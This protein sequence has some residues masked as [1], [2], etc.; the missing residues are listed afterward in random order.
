MSPHTGYANVET[1]QM[2]LIQRINAQC[3]SAKDDLL[4]GLDNNNMMTF[5]KVN[6]VFIS[7]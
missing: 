1:M 4:D 6:I 5:Q 2:Q 7:M 3:S